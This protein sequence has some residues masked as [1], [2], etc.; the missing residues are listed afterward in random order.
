MYSGMLKPRLLGRIQACRPSV[1]SELARA[2][3]FNSRWFAD[4]CLSRLPIPHPPYRNLDTTDSTKVK[5]CQTQIRSRLLI[6]WIEHWTTH[7]DSVGQVG[8]VD[9]A[10]CGLGYGRRRPSTVACL[11]FVQKREQYKA[12]LLCLTIRTSAYELRSRSSITFK[13]SNRHDHASA[14]RVR[15]RDSYG[16]IEWMMHTESC[17]A[18]MTLGV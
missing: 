11:R 4:R 13:R 12:L 10:V 3:V 7:W 16:T 2:K 5:I 8:C 17:L 15:L 1:L 18:I 6:I 9:L 14:S